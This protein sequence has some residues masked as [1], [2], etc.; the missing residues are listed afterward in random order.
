MPRPAVNVELR[1]R[2]KTGAAFAKVEQATQRLDNRLGKIGGTLGKFNGIFNPVTLG[3]GAATAATAALTKTVVDLDKIDKAAQRAG[4]S[5]E[6]LQAVRAVAENVGKGV[7][8][9]DTALQRFNRRLGEAQDGTGVLLPVL[10]DMGIE[11][12]DSAG[13]FRK[14]S[15]VFEEFTNGLQ[16]ITNES[17]L[18]RIAS[19]AFDTEGVG[20]G[21]GLG[22]LK[23]PLADFA[24]GLQGV[25]S[26]ESV[27]N[28]ADLKQAYTD[29]SRVIQE[30]L[31]PGVSILL[32]GLTDVVGLLNSAAQVDD[33][34][35][36]NERVENLE[37]QQA[38]LH[39]IV[40]EGPTLVERALG[41]TTES[42]LE[43]LGKINHDLE[44]YRD[45]GKLLVKDEETAAQKREEN[46]AKQIQ[47]TQKIEEAEKTSLEILV[48]RLNKRQQEQ[49]QLAKDLEIARNT[50]QISEEIYQTER[51]KLDVV[52]KQ[53]EEEE[54]KRDALVEQQR[55]EDEVAAVS[56][57]TRIDFELAPTAE[58]G[59]QE[60]YD[61][62]RTQ[63]DAELAED[64][65]KVNDNFG[66]QQ[67][68]LE[69]HTNQVL[70]RYGQLYQQ[71]DADRV[72]SLARQ[73]EE[74]QAAWENIRATVGDAFANFKDNAE[75]WTKLLLGQLPKIID[76]LKGVGRQGEGL[77][78][79]FG[80]GGS[81]IGSFVNSFFG[82]G[83]QQGPATGEQSEIPPP[84]P[85]TTRKWT[86]QGEQN[87]P[88][89][90]VEFFG[91][92]ERI[93]NRGS[94]R[95][96]QVGGVTAPIY[97]D[98]GQV[99]SESD[100]EMIA[101]RAAQTAKVQIEQLITNG[102]LIPA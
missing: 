59:T 7:E 28:A 49:E 48:E 44:H 89:G 56:A 12:I 58:R 6:R 75:G 31:N 37:K 79:L 65:R 92:A 16:N 72:D 24:A 88:D 40:S 61:Q 77:A 18:A 81:A 54:R 22:K 5:A 21:I 99:R 93:G 45:V 55:I 46:A 91:G 62:R 14:T 17:E 53:A 2:D 38:T 50:G 34:E 94:Q 33:V 63:L 15:D 78:G 36:N 101:T 52:R 71:L 19:A 86:P 76:L 4:Q 90:E 43:A 64:L 60:F 9:A 25:H 1:A 11:L 82:R 87:L 100:I 83:Q 102:R 73:Q 96:S 30:Q 80:G 74:Y 10:E 27:K 41:I 68:L 47:T 51:A 66:E 98:I 97:I 8:V 13:N 35:R 95:S 20:L 70:A 39:R 57:R 23:Q 3:I 32:R 84:P 26:N 85:F 69:V 29:F 42:A 67:A